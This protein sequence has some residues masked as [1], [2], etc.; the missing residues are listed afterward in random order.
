MNTVLYARLARTHPTALGTGSEARVLPTPSGATGQQVR[1]PETDHRTPPPARQSRTGPARGGGLSP[2]P[3][4]DTAA[5][6]V[7]FLP[8][9]QSLGPDLYARPGSAAD[10]GSPVLPPGPGLPAHLLQDPR[11]GPQPEGLPGSLTRAPRG[12]PLQTTSLSA[13][14]GPFPHPQ[15]ASPAARPGPPR[16]RCLLMAAASSTAQSPAAPHP[17][18]S[19]PVAPGA[20]AAAGGGA[21]GP[22]WDTGQHPARSPRLR[23]P[24]SHPHPRRS[25]CGP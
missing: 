14:P 18:V 12:R 23:S 11:E 2:S 8:P 6:C 16:C 20:A 15:P 21:T 19:R 5:C 22:S 7:C 17:S 25:P 4:L 1:V 10:P 24:D 9:G 13:W 3:G